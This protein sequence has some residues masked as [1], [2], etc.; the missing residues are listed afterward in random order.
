[1]CGTTALHV[2]GVI[3]GH[4]SNK[5]KVSLKFLRLTGMIFAIYGIYLFL[6]IFKN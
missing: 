5:N 2:F 4:I 3:V 6:G 1:M